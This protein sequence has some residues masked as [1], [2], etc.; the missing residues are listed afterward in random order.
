MSGRGWKSGHQLVPYPGPPGQV[1]IRVS[2]KYFTYLMHQE[3]GIK[4]FLMT[5]VQG[6]TLPLSCSV[7]DGPHFRRGGHVGE[8]G[9]VDIPHKGRTWRNQRWRHPGLQPKYFMRDALD[10]AIKDSH[11]D[12]KQVV[13]KA[14]RGEL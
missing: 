9:Y 3:R 10:R 2:A 7:G 8:P 14:L 4:P 5:W 6:K 1:G 11:N 12:I 13:M